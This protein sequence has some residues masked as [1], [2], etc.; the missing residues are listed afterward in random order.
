[1]RDYVL[2]MDKGSKTIVHDCGDWERAV[3]TRQLCKH[4]GKV[5]LSIPEQT[6]LG[7]VSAIQESLD[8]WKFQQPEK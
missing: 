6:A 7:W 8:S 1:I 2:R 3:D 4:I 5:L